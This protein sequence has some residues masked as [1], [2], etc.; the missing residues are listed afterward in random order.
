MPNDEQP[1]TLPNEVRVA[2]FEISRV[3][4]VRA[5]AGD[6]SED[7]LSLRVGLFVAPDSRPVLMANLSVR[8]DGDS[9][10]ATSQSVIVSEEDNEFWD[11]TDE[12]LEALIKG[13]SAVHVA[14]DAAAQAVR[15]VATMIVGGANVPF[16]T[17]DF[18]VDILRQSAEDEDEVSE[19][20]VA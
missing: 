4:A 7:N 20:T 13:S 16:A 9:F 19:S 5:V 1:M 14:Y 12:E 18:E 6:E 11:R 10:I 15:L 3:Q 8:E 17:P 2:G